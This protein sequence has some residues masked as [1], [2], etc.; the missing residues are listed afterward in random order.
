MEES[1][2]TIEGYQL[3]RQWA[4]QYR[5]KLNVEFDAFG[6]GIA[7]TWKPGPRHR[8]GMR[9]LGPEENPAVAMQRLLKLKEEVDA[10]EKE[11]NGAIS[12]RPRQPYVRNRYDR[13]TASTLVRT[14]DPDVLIRPLIKEDGH[15]SGVIIAITRTH[16]MRDTQ[17]LVPPQPLSS[18]PGSYRQLDK[19]PAA[20]DTTNW[21]RFQA[22]AMEGKEIWEWDDLRPLSGSGGIAVVRDGTVLERKVMMIA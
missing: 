9:V 16:R 3:F 17:V 13:E 8:L 5:G 10:F 14:E 20:L 1:T 21:P 6:E 7:V 19:Y 22:W 18:L 2:S 15:G 12:F 4:Q 11:F